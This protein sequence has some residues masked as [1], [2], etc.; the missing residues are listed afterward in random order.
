MLS[1]PSRNLYLPRRDRSFW[2]A[3]EGK[4]WSLRY[5]AWGRREFSE[6]NLPPCRHE[7]WVSLLIQEGHP[8]II[9]RG[10]KIELPRG[11]LMLIGP[12]C[13]FGWTRRQGSQCKFVLWMW[14]ELRLG[15]QAG[16]E[17]NGFQKFNLTKTRQEP[18]V[19]NHELC[20]R[21]AVATDGLSEKYFESC[22]MG[23][24]VLM[25]RLLE[26]DP[27]AP[28]QDRLE[29]AQ[30][31]I[32]AHLDSKKPVAR[33]C[34]YLNVSQS[35]LHRLF[36]ERVGMSPA[37]FIQKLKLQWAHD[38]LVEGDLLVKE[39]ALQLGYSQ[40]NDFSRAFKSF[41]GLSPSEVSRGKEPVSLD[42]RNPAE[43]RPRAGNS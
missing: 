28:S 29:Q 1:E 18:F 8:E 42:T 32:L 33:L 30:D 25:Q 40:F 35:S 5:L 17:E 36:K 23:F 19:R 14:D 12:E 7:G 2:Q 43:A 6:E 22:R 15:E 9:V 10:E 24:E 31:W 4:D 13:P 11:V 3:G 26:G 38:R 37:A 16:C 27:E 21:E 20:R 34:D 39:V 41:F